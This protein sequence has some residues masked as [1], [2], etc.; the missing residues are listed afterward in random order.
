MWPDGVTGLDHTADVGI[1]VRAPTLE[2]LFRRA[3]AGMVALVGGVEE[4]PAADD[5]RPSSV[6]GRAG[7]SIVDGRSSMGPGIAASSAEPDVSGAAN[8]ESHA[9]ELA[10]PDREALLVAWLREVLFLFQTRAFQYVDAHFDV[11]SDTRLVA[12][13]DGT[14]AEPVMELKGVT[15]HALAVRRE[16]DGWLARVVFDV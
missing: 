14:A 5:R 13:L 11:L 16:D 9:V 3:A 12:R 10:A 15:Y 8:S 4:R 1:A 2:E 6:R 7:S